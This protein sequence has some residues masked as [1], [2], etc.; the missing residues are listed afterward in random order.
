MNRNKSGRSW[1]T[2]LLGQSGL[3]KQTRVWARLLRRILLGICAAVLV[4]AAAVPI[5]AQRLDGTLRITVSDTTGASVT[6]ARV[7]V[8]NEATK[9]SVSTNVS[10]EG[11]Y[12]LPNLLVGSY[13]ITVEKEGFKK[14]VVKNVEVNSNQV[15]DA[16]AK[17]EVGDITSTMEVTTGAELVQTDSS[18]L[19]S[20]LGGRVANEVPINTL[21]GSVLE[22]AVGLPNTTTQE[23]GVLGSGGSI[24]GTRPRFNGFSIDGV[25][26]NRADVNGPITP[27]IQDSV[28]EFTLLTNQYSAEYGHSAGGQFIITTKSGTNNWHGEAHEYNQNKDFFA[29][30]NLQKANGV[31]N[32][33]DY[34]RAGASVGGPIKK[35]RL[36]VFGAYEF[37]NNGLA[38][39]S[40]VIT[41]PTQQGLANINSLVKPDAAIQSILAQTP[42]APTSD[43]LAHCSSGPG[44]T[45][46]ELACV[47]TSTGAR[48]AIDVGDIQAL[49][50]NFSNEYDFIVNTDLN[51][52]K[53]QLRGRVLYDRFRS[54]AIYSSQPQ[55]QFNGK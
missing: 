8:T 16:K 17:I 50:P 48:T 32:R 28:A 25:D 13:S 11:T 35:D 22:L 45:V 41:V 21:G 24:G 34:N 10:S 18:Q 31:K 46:P 33:F 23:G 40:P 44:D 27:V 26:D 30:D 52:G 3:P 38:S 53:H 36:F 1:S 42:V 9:V 39:G 6:D 20:T 19:S 51:L 5:H 14:Y 7:T 37:Q 2:R 15:T 29:L 55:A 49:A 4:P 47:T 12:V 43:G 54:P